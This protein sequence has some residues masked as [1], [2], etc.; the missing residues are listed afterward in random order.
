MMNVMD[1]LKEKIKDKDICCYSYDY[2]I[3]LHNEYYINLHNLPSYNNYNCFSVNSS[4]MIYELDEYFDGYYLE[5][6]FFNK[7]ELISHYRS[8]VYQPRWV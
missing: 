7:N 8:V 5:C 4:K 6:D 3:N 1:E 2:Y